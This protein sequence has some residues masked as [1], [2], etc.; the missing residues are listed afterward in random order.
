LDHE[1]ASCETLAA[2]NRRLLYRWSRPSNGF[3][4]ECQPLGD[5]SP[6][7]RPWF[8]ASSTIRERGKDQLWDARI[9]LTSNAISVRTY[10]ATSLQSRQ[11]QQAP[12]QCQ[13][14]DGGKR[15]APQP[16]RLT[17]HFFE[18]SGASEEDGTEVKA[19]NEQ[20]QSDFDPCL[21]ND[22]DGHAK[23]DQHGRG[24]CDFGRSSAR[25]PG[26]QAFL[27][28]RG[29]AHDRFW[30]NAAQ[31]SENVELSSEPHVPNAVNVF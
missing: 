7:L 2:A 19:Q 28:R 22:I 12:E 24:R 15:N 1:A 25:P 29:F 14:L 17:R 6:F 9:S 23:P 30:S 20:D 5:R 27:R 13:Q 21:T 31:L 10:P 16:T 8:R 4:W 3:R 11:R 26:R 18:E